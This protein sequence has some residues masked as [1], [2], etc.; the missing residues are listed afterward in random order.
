MNKE[1]ISD[2]HLEL[3]LNF[4]EQKPLTEEQLT[5]IKNVFKFEKEI[6]A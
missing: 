1:P 4:Y 5:V 2:E 6:D 3:L